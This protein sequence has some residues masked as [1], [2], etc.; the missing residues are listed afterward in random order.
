[1][2]G[3][4]A[5]EMLK[6]GAEGPSWSR[7]EQFPLRS[8]PASRLRSGMIIRLISKRVRREGPRDGRL[9]RRQAH[10]ARKRCGNHARLA[11]P[12]LSP[13]FGLFVLVGAAAASPQGTTITQTSPVRWH[14]QSGNEGEVPGATA[15]LTRTNSGIGFELHATELM[16]GT[17]YTLWLVR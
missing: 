16:P 14:A 11:E 6:V 15:T 4:R 12:R 5:Q 3:V 7:R 8:R 1:M 9:D 2:L 10:E 17:A 13:R